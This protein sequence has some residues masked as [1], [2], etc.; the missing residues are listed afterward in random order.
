MR[1][2]EQLDIEL[3]RVSFNELNKFYECFDKELSKL[4]QPCTACGGC[5]N[6]EK[7][8][9]RLYVTAL[10]AAYFFSHYLPKK[11]SVDTCPYMESLLCTAREHRFLGCRSYFRLHNKAE[12]EQAQALHERALTELKELHRKHSLPWR[13]FDVMS[14][15]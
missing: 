15:F 5:C 12:S 1:S 4:P 9:H 3:Y 14:L 8:E 6:F 13:Y 7:A 2:L 11:A 10:E